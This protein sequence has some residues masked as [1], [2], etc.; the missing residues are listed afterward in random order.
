VRLRQYVQRLTLDE[1]LT[2]DIVQESILEMYRV[3]AKLQRADRF[4]GWLRGIAFN[5]VRSHYG[6][7]WR[8][9]TVNLSD[10]A[11]EVAD[12]NSAGG[13]ADLVTAELKQIVIDSMR[14]LEPRHRAILTLRCYENLPYAEIAKN[15]GCSEFGARALFYRAKKSLAKQLG[16]HGF[17]RGS[18][19]MALVIFGKITAQSKT[20]VAGVSATAASLK[21]GVPAATA[22]VLLSKTG[23][24]TL[25]AIGVL[26]AGTM[27]ASHQPNN[28]TGRAGER[29]ETASSVAAQPA[30]ANKGLEQWWYYY[31]KGAGG[32]V[33]MRVMAS[34][35][36]GE[37]MRCLWRQNE[38]GSYR[39][40]R[41]NNTIYIENYR[42]YNS[43]LSVFRL[44]TDG[45]ELTQFIGRMEGRTYDGDYIAG[46]AE[47]LLVIASQQGKAD[48]SVRHISY[49]YGLLEEEYFSY[50]LPM[51]V[52]LVDERD[53]MHWRGWTY[54]RLSGQINGETVR[55]AGRIP[56]VYAA[57]R[58]HSAWLRLIV[59]AR[60]IMDTS[61][62]GLSRPWMG[63]HTI[64]VVRRDAARAHV[65][66]R[67]QRAPD[68]GAEVRLG[69]E[70]GRVVYTIDMEKDLIEKITLAGKGRDGEL[71]FSYLEDVE[72][73]ADEFVEPKGGYA[74]GQAF[75]VFLDRN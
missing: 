14:S 46:R 39:L 58:E 59:G 74:E 23:L 11:G 3:F 43:D 65:G 6:R 38:Q 61:F 37:P 41:A 36:P 13:L 31:P 64:D 72:G 10:S 28:Q 50:P 54:F 63:L 26:G 32:P 25:T 9:R 20:A 44:P 18:V 1:E 60:R 29:A 56:F 53:A 68:G 49:E 51:G 15:M 73:V 30:A 71:V 4:W 48:E 24:V 12:K 62:L 45:R 75:D 21:V 55:G 47:G 22:A 19:L 5:K 35:G 16:R 70:Q 66:F 34:A 40:D 17:G 69:D 27:I 57:S 33:M 8:H 42:L 7:R 2:E 67:T 52:K